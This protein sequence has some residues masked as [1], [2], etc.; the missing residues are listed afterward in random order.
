MKNGWLKFTV[1]LFSFLFW[2]CGEIPVNWNR[3]FDSKDTIPFGTYVLRQE[4]TEIFPDSKVR[5]ISTTTYDHFEEIQ[6]EY[7]KDHYF[8]I[9]DEIIWDDATWEKIVEYV[10]NGGS[11][12]IS[13][14]APNPVLEKVLGTQTSEL[15]YASKLPAVSLSVKTPEKEKKYIFQKGAN[16]FYFSQLKD[17]T[18]EIL[19]YLEYNGEKK[20]NFI[21]VY[22]GEGY[23]LLHCEPIAFTNYHMLKKN[24]AEYVTDVFS[25]LS[26]E[27]I[28]WDNHRLFRR[29]SGERNDGGF[30]NGL[31]FLMKHEALRWAFFLL[32][33]MG[34]LYLFFNS[35]RR[36]RAVPIVLSYPNYTLDFAKT[37][38]E[39]YRYNADH[40]AMVRYKINYFLEQL[41]LHYYITP[42]DTE[43][44]FSEILSAKS[45]V[46][47]ET[48]RKLVLKID[49]LKSKN[50]LDK[51]DFY[52]LHTL[53]ESFKLKSKNYGRDTS[54][55]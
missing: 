18:T 14:N 5:N 11:A 21:K 32:V 39:L 4:L 54:R 47:F 34:L 12:F 2:S 9:Y 30:F 16:R 6:Y 1:F 15:L 25:Y 26:P 28:M 44:D 53:I 36:Q 43:K 19:G 24:H 3:T 10:N 8:F 13:V 48:C 40:T 29:Q 52:S 50:Y 23:F 42:K 20:P 17:E 41:R 55:K 38:S 7:R 37:L 35:K 33:T 49:I 31:S 46:D 22:H 51:E 45:G 27:D